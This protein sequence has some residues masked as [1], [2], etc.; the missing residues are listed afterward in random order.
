MDL[1][2]TIEELRHRKQKIDRVI[3]LLEGFDSGVVSAGEAKRKK[4]GANQ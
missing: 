2:K 3:A 1:T 4:G